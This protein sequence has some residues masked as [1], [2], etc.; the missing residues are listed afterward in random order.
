MDQ[1]HIKR[2]TWD[3]D[4]VRAL[5]IEDL[6]R[7]GIEV[8]GESALSLVGMTVVLEF[9]PPR[10]DQDE[11]LGQGEGGSGGKSANQATR[12]T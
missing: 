1:H 2:F 9:W 8:E 5:L 6:A 11:T 12:K 4:E 3:K 10:M 7:Q